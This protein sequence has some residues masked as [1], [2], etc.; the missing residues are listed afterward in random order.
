MALKQVIRVCDQCGTEMDG[1]TSVGQVEITDTSIPVVYP[2][3]TH[4]PPLVRRSRE[5][6]GWGCAGDYIAERSAA[7]TAAEDVTGG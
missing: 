4:P 7:S 2:E 6:C 3:I 5:F 1:R